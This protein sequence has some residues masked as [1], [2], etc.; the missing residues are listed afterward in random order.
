[1]HLC[2]FVCVR[3]ATLDGNLG[4][5]LLGGGG[6]GDR[7]A[8][9]L[10]CE[11]CLLCLFFVLFLLPL[12]NDTDSVEWRKYAL[13]EHQT[14][15]INTHTWILSL[16]KKSEVWWRKAAVV[17]THPEPGRDGVRS[18]V[19]R[20]RTR[21]RW[22]W[23]LIRKHETRMKRQRTTSCTPRSTTPSH[24]FRKA[25]QKRSGCK[26]CSQNLRGW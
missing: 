18:S 3:V 20:S 17:R 4:F 6:G 14:H 12:N 1:M 5:V 21:A 13:H 15:E 25:R 24:S 2:V 16:K 26:S 10:H 8:C 11:L 22:P 19:P 23:E 7:I 9:A